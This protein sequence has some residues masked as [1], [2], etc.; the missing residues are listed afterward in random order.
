MPTAPRAGRRFRQAARRRRRPR[1][2]TSS[3]RPAPPASTTPA[4]RR[5]SSCSG[6]RATASSPR[7]TS[8]ARAPPT[9]SR[10]AA[11]LGFLGELADH[12]QHR[13][14]DRLAHGAIGG[15]AHAAQRTRD[16]ARRHSPTSPELSAAPRT[17]C[18][19]I[20]PELPRAPISAPRATSLTSPGRSSV[21]VRSSWLDAPTEQS[22]RD[23]S[24]C[25]RR[26]PDTR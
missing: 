2:R 24:P 22:G 16:R 14:L 17:I 5:T 6:V 4:S 3:S 23:S 9:S 19:K 12:R 7:R 15:V 18:E 26:A 1:P 21:V 20:T 8:A 25:R 10:R 11:R 13:P